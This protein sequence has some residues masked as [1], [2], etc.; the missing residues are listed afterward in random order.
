[1]AKDGLMNGPMRYRSAPN[2]QI[3]FF[4]ST[5]GQ[6]DVSGVMKSDGGPSLVAVFAVCWGDAYCSDYLV[7]GPRGVPDSAISASSVFAFNGI[8]HDPP[9]GRLYMAKWKSSIGCPSP[10]YPAWCCLHGDSEPYIQIFSGPTDTSIDAVTHGVINPPIIAQYIRIRP[11]TWGQ[12]PEA[13]PCLRFD[14]I[15]CSHDSGR[16]HFAYHP[17]STNAMID[18]ELIANKQV[19]DLRE[20]SLQ[21]HRDVTCH[22]FFY[23]NNRRMC[24]KYNVNKFI[25]NEPGQ[26]KAISDRNFLYYFDMTTIDLYM[27]IDAQTGLVYKVITKKYTKAVAMETCAEFG[28]RL[29]VVNSLDKLDLLQRVKASSFILEKEPLRVNGGWYDVDGSTRWWDGGEPSQ[30]ILDDL[31]IWDTTAVTPP[32]FCLT[33]TNGEVRRNMCTSEQFSICGQ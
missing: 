27:T 17:L 12:G 21:C 13:P 15:G 20:C 6:C 4:V 28:M 10:H 8:H 2:L 22:S 25:G 23:N 33:Y 5:L 11:L 30:P 9:C 1:M 31:V 16:R 32:A 24:K 3:F 14:V 18:S 26:K 19:T 29:L 7:S